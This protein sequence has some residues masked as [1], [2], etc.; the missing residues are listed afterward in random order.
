MDIV[1]FRGGLGNQMFQYALLEALKSRGRDARASTGFYRRY[2]KAMPY[3]LQKAFPNIQIQFVN[4]KQFDEI[5]KRWIEIKK[6]D[7]LREEFCRNYKERF[8]F[9]EDLSES[10]SFHPEVFET[11]NCVFV[12]C[13]QSERYF[14]ENTS[15][16]LEKF[17][18]DIKNPQIIEMGKL[19][20]REGYTSVHVRRGDY[21]LKESFYMNVCTE[22]Y[23]QSAINKILKKDANAKFI[24]FSDDIEWVKDNIKVQNAIY[25]DAIKTGDYCDWYDMYLMSKC[26]NNI[27]ANST[28]SWWGAWLNRTKDKM[29]IAPDKWVYGNYRTPDIWCDDWIKIGG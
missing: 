27:I 14:K 25:S 22:K 13:W 9:V 1:R 16:L 26:R 18:F 7:Q 28:F 11:Q 23:Y 20:Q 19:L 12:G 3:C 24:F 15:L 10:S 17:T 21:L 2:P 29:V 4:D 5:D 6:N 8:F